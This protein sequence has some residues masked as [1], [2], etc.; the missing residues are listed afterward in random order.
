MTIDLNNKQTQEFVIICLVLVV[1]AI[2]SW[3]MYK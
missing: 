2:Q 1:G 3:R